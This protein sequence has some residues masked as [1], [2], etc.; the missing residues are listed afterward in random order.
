MVLASPSRPENCYCTQAYP[1]FASYFANIRWFPMC[2]PC[3]RMP[4]DMLSL[5]N[6]LPC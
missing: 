1:S 4:C 5:P 6:S 2:S 3:A